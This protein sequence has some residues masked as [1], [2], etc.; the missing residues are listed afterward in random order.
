M[1]KKTLIEQ[2]L[3]GMGNIDHCLDYLT[4]LCVANRGKKGVP[5]LSYRKA[6]TSIKMTADQSLVQRQSTYAHHSKL[7]SLNISRISSN[8]FS[9][10]YRQ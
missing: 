2:V 7:S 1:P 3:T 4:K 5:P 10:P 8:D 6:M 9:A